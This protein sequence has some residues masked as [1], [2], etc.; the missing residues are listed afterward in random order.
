[1]SGN[2]RFYP[3]DI[4]V[5][6]RRIMLFRSVLRTTKLNLQRCPIFPFINAPFRAYDTC[7]RYISPLVGNWV[8]WIF[9]SRENTNFTYQ[10][11]DRCKVN[12]AASLATLLQRDY[13]EIVGYF[14]EIETD[15]D[16]N[17]HIKRLWLK[18]PAK[19]RTTET[20]N[21][22]RR[23]VVCDCARNQT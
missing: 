9:T 8:A 12:L 20:A 18:H 4:Q 11:T 14:H 6:Q 13:T 5:S 1:M 3:Q 10:L 15:G 7:R 2:S 16:F 21:V 19:Y 22:G 23:M 17:S